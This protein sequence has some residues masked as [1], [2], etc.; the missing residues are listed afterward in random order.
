MKTDSYVVNVYSVLAKNGE[1]EDEKKMKATYDGNKIDLFFDDN[2]QVIERVI[3]NKMLKDIQSNIDE[4]NELMCRLIRDF[5]TSEPRVTIKDDDDD[6]DEFTTSKP[7]R[8]N[9]TTKAKKSSSRKSK[10]VKRT[11]K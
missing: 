4:R 8:K 7:K 5:D 6:I 9:K 2:G 11:K 3:S 1:V 10:T